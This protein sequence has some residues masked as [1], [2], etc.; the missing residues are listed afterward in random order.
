MLKSVV[1]KQQMLFA[2][3]YNLYC[4]LIISWVLWVIL[5]DE[6]FGRVMFIVLYFF[7]FF[8]HSFLRNLAFAAQ[9]LKMHL[10]SCFSDW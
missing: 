10:F 1:Q 4:M 7:L 8:Q 9:D 2:W 3:L 5:A 6:L